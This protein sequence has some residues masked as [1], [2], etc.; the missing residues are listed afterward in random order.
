MHLVIS[1]LR[2]TNT[3]YWYDV[4]IVSVCSARHRLKQIKPSF[5]ARPRSVAPSNGGI[6]HDHGSQFH[7][8]ALCYSFITVTCMPYL[9]S[10]L[11]LRRP[12][13]GP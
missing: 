10:E 1:L 12:L 6:E 2:R 5:N 9:Q 8:H 3:H 7:G 4:P 13:H 11:T